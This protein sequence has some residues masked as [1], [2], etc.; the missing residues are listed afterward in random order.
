MSASGIVFFNCRF[1][2]TRG[3]RFYKA[4][5]RSAERPNALINCVLPVES[6]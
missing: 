1:E 6:P 2:A 5:F 3:M 4:E